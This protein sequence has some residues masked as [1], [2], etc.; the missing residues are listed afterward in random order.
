MLPPATG[1]II[2]RSA[3]SR[4]QALLRSADTAIDQIPVRHHPANGARALGI[5]VCGHAFH[6]RRGDRVTGLSIE[7]AAR[8]PCCAVTVS[9]QARRPYQRLCWALRERTSIMQ[10]PDSRRRGMLRLSRTARQIARWSVT[11]GHKWTS[12]SAVLHCSFDHPR[13]SNHSSQSNS[14]RHKFGRAILSAS[15]AAMRPI[16]SH[17]SPECRSTIFSLLVARSTC[18]SRLGKQFG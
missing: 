12:S 7:V 13:L 10:Q 15:S 4:G 18:V 2:S 17:C 16:C 5:E 9:Q 1:G 6:R 3:S 8:C 14:R 11:F